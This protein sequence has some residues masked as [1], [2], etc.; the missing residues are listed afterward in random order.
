ML[1]FTYVYPVNLRNPVTNTIISILLMK[2]LSHREV[3]QIAT[4][5]LVTILEL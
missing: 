5:I 3:K 1:Y 4:D 2:K